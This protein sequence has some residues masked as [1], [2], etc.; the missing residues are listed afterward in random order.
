[1]DEFLAAYYGAGWRYIRAY[2]DYTCMEVK[3][4][5]M[6]I[7]SEPFSYIPRDKYEA[8][9]ETFENWWNK[10]EELAGERLEHVKRSRL[11]WQYIRLMLHPN[12]EEGKKLY[13]DAEGAGIMWREGTRHIESP[14]FSL[15]PTEWHKR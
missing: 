11:Q 12:A 2:I 14:D 3:N 8:M 6:N 5:H 10:A 15:A 7:W 1:M 4:I 9:E 13:E